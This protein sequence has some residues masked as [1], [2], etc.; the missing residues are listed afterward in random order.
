MDQTFWDGMSGFFDKLMARCNNEY[1]TIE[2]YQ[3]K[4]TSPIRIQSPINRMLM[5]WVTNDIVLPPTL[6]H[7]IVIF[8][9]MV[10][11]DAGHP[12]IDLSLPQSS[13]QDL[14]IISVNPRPMMDSII[15]PRS[16][17]KLL[18]V[19]S[20]VQTLPQDFPPSLT[21][22]TL[23]TTINET[24][25][26]QPLIKLQVET[27]PK[28]PKVPYPNL[29]QLI[30]KSMSYKIL[31]HI[32]SDLFPVL[33]KLVC[34]EVDGSP[35][36]KSVDLSRLPASLKQLDLTPQSGLQVVQHVD[37]VM[38]NSIKHQFT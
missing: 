17:T 8:N 5:E 32:T 37:K 19:S 33:E 2:F 23:S 6:T 29:V 12:P 14:M 35:D 7:L 11:M 16:L 31:Q 30:F 1:P 10:G 25:H 26:H 9:S 24:I 3:K 34:G 20:L 22:L 13:L 4:T 27:F 28:P 38:A 21:D 18:V 15:Q 36:T